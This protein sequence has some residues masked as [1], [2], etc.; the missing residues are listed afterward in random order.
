MRSLRER[1]QQQR[2]VESEEAA[3]DS[4]APTGAAAAATAAAAG[5]STVSEIDAMLAANSDVDSGFDSDSDDGNDNLD[6]HIKSQ[7]KLFKREEQLD[8][9]KNPLKWWAE[10]EK[11]YDLIAPV[12]RKWLAVPASSAASERLFS[13]AGLTV[14]D[15]RSRLTCDKIESLVFL[16]TAW[17]ALQKMGVLY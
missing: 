16:K 2:R 7:V 12:A 6:R 14:S 8:K 5:S 9:K 10:H 15:K 13:S 4:Y 11:T 17:P 3:S 1:Q